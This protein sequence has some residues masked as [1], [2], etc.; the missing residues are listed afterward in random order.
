M[1]LGF[2][3]RIMTWT[4]EHDLLLCREVLVVNPYTAL[5]GSIDRGNLW[6]IISSNLNSIDQPRFIVDRRSVR[7]HLAILVKNFNKRMK[8]EEKQSGISPHIS[9]VDQAIMDII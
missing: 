5:K 8:D 3:S 9:E 1:N 6:G 2:S 4:N 7:D